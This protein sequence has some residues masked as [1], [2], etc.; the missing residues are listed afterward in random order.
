[1]NGALPSVH[2]LLKFGRVEAGRLRF[3]VELIQK[4]GLVTAKLVLANL[5]L[6]IRPPQATSICGELEYAPR[7]SLERLIKY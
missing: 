3:G 2:Y 7:S 6:S 4:F 5:K 1:M